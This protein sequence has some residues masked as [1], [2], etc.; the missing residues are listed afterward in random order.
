CLGKAPRTG[1]FW[2]GLH[3]RPSATLD[4][5]SSNAALQALT[6][7]GTGGASV[8][9]GGAYS[10]GHRMFQVQEARNRSARMVAAATATT[11]ATEGAAKTLGRG[12]ASGDDLRRGRSPPSS[13]SP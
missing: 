9:A 12:M 11:V 6:R 10:R 5:S 4:A 2:N 3:A 7:M 1:S 8:A 13:T